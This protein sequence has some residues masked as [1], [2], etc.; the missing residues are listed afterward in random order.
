MT[1]NIDEGG[2]GGGEQKLEIFRLKFYRKS[3]LLGE[4][5]MKMEKKTIGHRRH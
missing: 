5:K 1:N 2:G 3:F 4:Q